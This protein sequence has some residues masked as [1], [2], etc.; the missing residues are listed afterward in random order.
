MAVNVVLTL[1]L[2]LALAQLGIA[3]SLSI[4][5]WVN[6]LTL[7]AVLGRRRQFALDRR[8]RRA[9][10]RIALSALGMGGLV[11]LLEYALAGA[12]AGG[13][14]VKLTALVVLVSGGLF[15]FGLLALL[16]GVAD[17][18]ELAGRVRR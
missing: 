15:G 17:W 10:P 4:A 2:G 6:A 7:I 9:L 3:L 16:L 12:F 13:L 8:T 5:G 11:L 14:V 1:A 18:R